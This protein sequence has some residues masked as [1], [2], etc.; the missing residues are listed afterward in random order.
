[1]IT[2]LFLIPLAI[3]SIIALAGD[4]RRGLKNWE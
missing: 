2:G 3:L 4:N 1:M